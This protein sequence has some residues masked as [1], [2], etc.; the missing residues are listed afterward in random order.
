MTCA[1]PSCENE[2]PDAFVASID[3]TEPP[4][5]AVDGALLYSCAL[6][7]CSIECKSVWFAMQNPTR[8]VFIDAKD[9]LRHKQKRDKH[10]WAQ[11]ARL[12]K[13]GYYDETHKTAAA[14]RKLGI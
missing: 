5:Y 11:S 14:R 12:N 6:F 1:S 7:F 13:S 9:S 3:Q 2:I 10:L 8:P 4:L